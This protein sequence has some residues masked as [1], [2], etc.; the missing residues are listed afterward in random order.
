MIDVLE[1]IVAGICGI[2]VL[3]TAGLYAFFKLPSTV[4]TAFLPPVSEE[5]R[6]VAKP[7]PATAPPTASVDPQ[8]QALAEKL[9]LQER[10]VSVK[11]L[12]DNK[13]RL[14]VPTQTFEHLRAEANWLPSLKTAKSQP[15]MT[16][17]GTTRLRIYDI[18]P[19]SLLQK[20]G[21]QDDDVIELINGE[22]VTFD[23]SNTR[24][25]YDMAEAA[26]RDLQAGKSIN[27]VVTRKG[28]LIP[29]EFRLESR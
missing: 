26:I 18:Q 16:R 11:E 15:L 13:K 19:H 12:Q 28:R 1:K 7:A 14:T 3:L 22:I 10:K 29:L 23:Q 5:E 9:A 6:P 24:K 17:N 8:L 25:Y 27:V 21:F 2:L 20:L 4:P